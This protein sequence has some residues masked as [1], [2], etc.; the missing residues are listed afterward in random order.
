M[1]TVKKMI[2]ILLVLILFCTHCAA[3][4]TQ[5]TSIVPSV[6]LQNVEL[7]NA[8]NALLQ[9]RLLGFA[10][11]AVAPRFGSGSSSATMTVPAAKSAS[12]MS[13]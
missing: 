8:G 5:L 13:S 12:T 2:L 3:A 11:P 10:I 1:S 6:V 9:D 4:F 7:P